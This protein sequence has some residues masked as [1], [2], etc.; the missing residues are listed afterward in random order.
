MKKSF[1]DVYGS[2]DSEDEKP[3]NKGIPK[4]VVDLGSKSKKD[5]KEKTPEEEDPEAKF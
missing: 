3:T 4:H 2:D 1:G 5:P